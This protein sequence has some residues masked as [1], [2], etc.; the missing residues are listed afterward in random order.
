MRETPEKGV[1]V[2]GLK[3][4]YVTCE[5]DVIN[6][7]LLGEKY[8][9]V[10][11]TKM[12]ASSSRSHSLFIL[13]L[14]Q[15][16]KDGSTKE[17]RLNLA[18]L[19]GSEKV[20]KTGATGETLEEAKKINQS[21]SALGNCI[22][23][24][25][26]AKKGHV[27]YRD[28]KLTFI[29]R[30]SLGGNCKT[31]LLVACSPH[32]FNLE[33][34]ISTLQFAKRAKSIKNSVKVNKQRSVAEL[35]AI[36][37]K[38]KKEL[39]YY[40]KYISCMETLL[41]QIK[42]ANWKNEYP[43]IAAF[44][45]N[46]ASV[47]LENVQNE[48]NDN[49]EDNDIEDNNSES[50]NNDNQNISHSGSQRN[51]PRK[52]SKPSSRVSEVDLSFK[53]AELEVEYQKIKESSHLE[54]RELKE[55]FDNLKKDNETNLP[56][57]EQK[58]L[59]MIE[60]LEYKIHCA[61]EE[62]ENQNQLRISIEKKFQS[63]TQLLNHFF[64]NYEKTVNLYSIEIDQHKMKVDYYSANLEEKLAEKEV[65]AH[66]T[67]LIQRKLEDTVYALNEKESR[68]RD[69]IKERDEFSTLRTQLEKEC[70]E[71]L[72]RQSVLD[73]KSHS[74]EQSLLSITQSNKQSDTH[75]KSVIEN[76]TQ[77]RSVLSERKEKLTEL[78]SSVLEAKEEV[79]NAKEEQYS[80]KH[81]DQ[82]KEIEDRQQTVD[83]EIYKTEVA[84]RDAL[85]S[86]VDKTTAEI[87]AIRSEIKQKRDDIDEMKTEHQTKL[88]TLST[89]YDAN[90][91]AYRLKI[92]LLETNLSD[93]Q[94]GVFRKLNMLDEK[95][96][97]WVSRLLSESLIH[98]A[99]K[100][101]LECIIYFSSFMR[102]VLTILS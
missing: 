61:K 14:H 24:L 85:K 89:E 54:V 36:I 95:L 98:S 96:N 44:L 16:S 56:I 26:K 68:L 21:L 30:E 63:D 3:E 49:E 8:R 32:I 66:E 60:N 73:E 101:K 84:E 102:F 5:E 59:Q 19:A 39:A 11:S 38:I 15:K 35:M 88:E 20:N 72:A 94:S 27:P 93:E 53:V 58:K 91:S 65:S 90:L 28:S 41:E 92:E 55:E 57:K 42:G 47:Q 4:E 13:S 31:T 51:T 79:L 77:L 46:S 6:L 70:D 9:A 23:A 52:K 78:Q 74:L 1:W 81:A 82:D 50:G 33:E 12:N 18:D 22:N 86:D 37:E 40:K 17:G 43:K 7:I 83:V 97:N 99:T 75:L 34:T 62:I 45:S 25:T 76:N 29:L 80:S 2:E 69:L 71:L 10:S 100:D 87:K 67:Q 64:E 48:N